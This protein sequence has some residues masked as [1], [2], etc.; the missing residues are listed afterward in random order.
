MSQRNRIVPKY[1]QVEQLL[2]G[3]V[4]SLLPGS[5]L[6]AE[7]IL[8]KEYGVSRA[9]LRV[10][11]DALVADGLLNRIQGRGTFASQTRLD[12]PVGYQA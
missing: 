7:P 12:I 1:F 3:R 6:P 2:R 8:A 11:V 5:P 10:A 9:T 4:S